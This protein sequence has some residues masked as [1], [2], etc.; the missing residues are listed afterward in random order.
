MLSLLLSVSLILMGVQVNGA[1]QARTLAA[2][3]GELEAIAGA[4]NDAAGWQA[5]ERGTG[6]TLL[7]TEKPPQPLVDR[8]KD[9]GARADLA[10]S[11]AEAHL[12]VLASLAPDE[13]VTRA[14]AQWRKALVATRADRERVLGHQVSAKEWV[15]SATATISR[16]FELRGAVL[17][18]ADERE[19]VLLLNAVL[20]ANVATLA[21]YA[22][23][24]RA[25]LGG[26]IASNQ[27][28]S[29]E[30][31]STLLG[32]R[33]VVDVAAAQVL[34][35]KESPST[36]PELKVAVGNFEREFLGEYQALRLGVYAASDAKAPYPL[37]GQ[38]WI[39]RSTK[40][41]DS[42]L[43]VSAAVG[44]LSRR[45]AA[46]I[47]S[48]AQGSLWLT[49]ALVVLAFGTFMF[50]LRFIRVKVVAPI[51]AVIEGLSEG[52]RQVADA[53]GSIAASS[54]SLAAGA[55]Q[56]AAA[57]EQTT[58]SL[59]DVSHR[60]AQ[61]AQSSQE[62]NLAA[63]QTAGFIAS[64]TQ[65]MREMEGAMA[66]ITRASREI[67]RIMKAID[68]IA[69]QTNML[70]LNAAVEAARAGEHGHGFAVVAEEVRSLAQRALVASRESA[71]QVG[72]A[73]KTTGSGATV[74]Q[75]LSEALSHISTTGGST[76]TLVGQIAT[77]S[78]EQADG[79]GQVSIAMGEMNQVVQRTAATAEESAAAAEQLSAQS[80]QLNAWVRELSTLV[81]GRRAA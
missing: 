38:E 14:A 69:F 78:R 64:G 70:A 22:G 46:S 2:R 48:S 47:A 39:A 4:L 62:A 66:D 81:G 59:G 33:A 41:I 72:E 40:A 44:E 50:V 23:R 73:M 57:L 29:P 42:S 53:S 28:I 11:Q 56:Q 58:R 51:N 31:R 68:D 54:Q 61:N 17:S 74:L 55:T 67:S 19:R 34:G 37:T 25:N 9:V 24:E 63:T 8:F 5:I 60:S 21:E 75:H 3:Y 65:S 1:L 16:E 76:S 18:P 52:S 26:V 15:G 49:A 7:N 12:A 32:F 71:E 10:T 43:A 36:P 6:T 27:P 35:L 79:L 45:S 13:G 30:L 77:A 20:R 80:E